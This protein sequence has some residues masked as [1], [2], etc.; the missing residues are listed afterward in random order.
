MKK[1]AAIALAS[2]SVTVGA[3]DTALDCD[4]AVSTLEINQCA[5]IELES[6]QAELT[7]YLEASFEHNVHDPELIE[8]IKMA[9][10]DWQDYMSSHCDS[11]YTQWRDGTIRGVMTISCKTKL[12][13]RRTHEIWSNFL[14]YM[15]GAPPVL[16]EP[17][18]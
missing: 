13:K 2:L 8:S 15:D 6:A 12:T 17:K 5:S 14:T 3:D 7:R 9:Q 18:W 11:V 10:K 16:P 4:N 1:W